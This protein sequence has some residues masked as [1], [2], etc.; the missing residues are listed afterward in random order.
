MGEGG[1]SERRLGVGFGIAAYGIWGLFP[2]YWPLLKPA[3]AGEIL[4]SRMTWSLAAVLVILAARRMP[5]GVARWSWVRPLARSRRRMLL[6]AVAA[7]TISVNWLVY[8]WAVNAGHVV[9]ASLGYFINPLVSVLFGVFMLREKLRR[10]QWTAVGIG[11]LAVLV[12]AVGYG[13]LPWIALTLAISFGTYGLVKKLAAVPAAESMA[14]E[15]SILFLPALGY[16]IWLGTHGSLAFGHHN[17]GNTALLALSGPVTV[18]PLIMFAGAANRLPL[19][20]VGLLQFLTPVLQFVCGVLVQ[21]ESVPPA[22]LAGF[23]IVWIALAVLTADALRAGRTSQ[24]ARRNAVADSG[25]A[26]SPAADSP[27]EP[28]ISVPAPAPAVS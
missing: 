10:A 9:D 3:S 17:G 11:A 16:L 8:I 5:A 14:I 18:V 4:A 21:H 13:K 20:M 1:N 25:P 6:L 12:L 2:L 19:S 26:A 23:L 24:T 15:T 7:C 28:G 22:R 27:A